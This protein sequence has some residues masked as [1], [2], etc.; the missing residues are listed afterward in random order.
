[1]HE[2][3]GMTCVTLG[4]TGGEPNGPTVSGRCMTTG[5]APHWRIPRAN[6][7]DDANEEGVRELTQRG[8]DGSEEAATFMARLYCN[9]EGASLFEKWGLLR[10]KP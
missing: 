6:D 3:V 9:W 10:C 5:R 7:W 1:M 2:P 8:I 4:G